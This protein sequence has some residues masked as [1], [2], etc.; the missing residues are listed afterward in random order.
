MLDKKKLDV[1]IKVTPLVLKMESDRL[2]PVNAVG[3]IHN[4]ESNDWWSVHYLDG[5]IP[6]DNHGGC[7]M[8]SMNAVSV[9]A[10]AKIGQFSVQQSLL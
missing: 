2:A 3:S 6:L 10:L 9:N 1:S 4:G 7:S 8:K 5:V